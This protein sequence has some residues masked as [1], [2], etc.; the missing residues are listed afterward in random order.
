[1]DTQPNYE[2]KNMDIPLNS[3]QKNTRQSLSK[4]FIPFS[5][6]K[7]FS[8]IAWLFLLV[9]SLVSFVKPE[10]PEK[11]QG[12]EIFSSFYIF[13][14]SLSV[15]IDGD[16]P[17]VPAMVYNGFFNFC[18]YSLITFIFFSCFFIFYNTFYKP[19]SINGMFERFSKF[20]FIPLLSVSALF[21]IGETLKIDDQIYNL[22][23]IFRI[24]S[25]DAVYAFN[26]IFTFIGL[27]LLIFI[28]LNT[29][30][31]DSK[32]AYYII[33]QITYGIL[34]ALLVYNFF[35]SIFFYGI[36][37]DSIEDTLKFSSNC[38][39]SFSILIGVV[40]LAITFFLKNIVTG[41]TNLFLYIG[42]IIWFFKIPVD[43]RKD[44][45]G[46]ADGIIDCIIVVIN[47]G[48]LVFL[49]I[50]HRQEILI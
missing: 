32:L 36:L 10:F 41:I 13:W 40:N 28:H 15:K 19:E 46:V 27:C 4:I 18:F 24:K 7:L 6:M 12:V 31:S 45:N 35:F 26:L 33:K 21:I 37:K 11:I 2:Q 3:E 20:H 1:M 23:K 48:V 47:L 39:L 22:E 38:G 42:M 43:F 5:N 9:S 29:N 50:K 16:T 49:F 25:I 8:L 34:M 44:Y 14:F 17:Y 30:L